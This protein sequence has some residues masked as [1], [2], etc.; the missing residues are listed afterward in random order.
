MRRLAARSRRSAADDRRQ[1]RRATG[2]YD[3][4]GSIR[5]MCRRPASAARLRDH[6]VISRRWFGPV[7]GELPLARLRLLAA[8]G[9]APRRQFSLFLVGGYGDRLWRTDRSKIREIRWRAAR[10]GVSCISIRDPLWYT[11]LTLRGW[12]LRKELR[13][14]DI[15][16][17]ISRIAG[18]AGLTCIEA[19]SWRNWARLWTLW[20][21]WLT[22]AEASP[23][24]ALP[25]APE[26]PVV[27][28][29]APARRRAVM[30][31]I[32]SAAALLIAALHCRRCHF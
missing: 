18:S 2:A 31:G 13:P 29:P 23:A 27:P 17:I 16:H 19:T 6:A 11:L 28:L 12:V 32:V 3:Q 1:E 14:V 20:D 8:I 4:L 21:V 25:A 10:L 7:P 5:Q 26:A 15:S 30:A 9:R 24:P 22:R